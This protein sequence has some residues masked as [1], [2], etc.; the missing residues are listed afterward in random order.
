MVNFC[1]L[2]DLVLLEIFSHLSCEDSLFAFAELNIDR[3]TNL[4][5]ERGAFQYIRLSSALSFER[6]LVLYERIWRRECIR[7]LVVEDM[8]ADMISYYTRSWHFP[9]L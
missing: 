9:S 8:F 1:S 7:S 4:L 6:Y 3:L 2:A 5:V